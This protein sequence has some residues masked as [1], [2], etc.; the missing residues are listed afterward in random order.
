MIKTEDIMSLKHRSVT[1]PMEPDPVDYFPLPSGNLVFPVSSEHFDFPGYFY[2]SPVTV[3]C[4]IEIL[5][6]Y[7]F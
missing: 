7:I 6:V 1:H 2:A 3:Q 4:N 5:S